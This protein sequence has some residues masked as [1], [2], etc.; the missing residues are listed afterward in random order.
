MHSHLMSWLSAC[1]NTRHVGGQRVMTIQQGQF[2]HIDRM[3]SCDTV[4]LLS[5][6][7]KI[8]KEKYES[9]QLDYTT[10]NNICLFII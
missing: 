5:H 8:H 1:D 7:L 10:Y 6:S 4:C 9:L 3:Y 2:S